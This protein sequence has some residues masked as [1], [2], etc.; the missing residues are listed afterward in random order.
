M[1]ALVL[2]D[3]GHVNGGAPKVAIAAT[4]ALHA[5]GTP[6]EFAYC[7][8]PPD[9]ALV[10]S[11]IPLHQVR[12]AN[13]WTK[14]N[15]LA[16][17]RDGV[18]NPSTRRQLAELLS[19]FDPADTVVH[20]HQWTKAF[21]PSVLSLPGELGFRHAVTL[22]DYFFACPN[23]ALY[24]F[25]RRRP[26]GVA[27]MSGACLRTNCDSRAYAH[28][29]VRVA[30]QALADRALAAAPAWPELVHVSDFARRMVAPYLP[31]GIG[32]H[33]VPNPVEVTDRGRAPAENYERAV[34]VGR[35]VPEKGVVLAA[36][37]AADA[38]MPITFV[39]DGPEANAIRLANP[40]AELVGWAEPARVAEI[41][42]TSRCLLF[43]S[44]WYETSG[45]V[46]AEALANGIPVIA[47][48]TTAAADLVGEGGGG[49]VVPPGDREALASA[50]RVV[51]Q[52]LRA[53]KMSHAAYMHFWRDP[54]SPAAH[55]AALARLYAGMLSR[56]L[57]SPAD[58][59][60]ARHATPEVA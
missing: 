57:P 19:R 13:V 37:A 40:R 58:A 42:R 2:S 5:Q 50:L 3:F 22:H 17:A 48:S 28:K 36:Q 29:L 60:A 12:A 11:G 59:P 35:L 56:P 39:G 14:R 49:I 21:S 34:Y 54:P 38:G 41:V 45:L 32:Q 24:D 10:A 25:N 9:E 46:C 18:W 20:S 53:V 16:A 31:A 26:C 47:S 4:L 23:G 44:T 52:P 6:V 8:G 33:V 43:P 1:R 7:V 15:P 55:A 30:R 27:P 51:R